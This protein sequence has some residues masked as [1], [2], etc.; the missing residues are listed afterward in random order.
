MLTVSILSAVNA[1]DHRPTGRDM[2]PFSWWLREQLDLRDWTQAD[3]S[4][5]SGVSTGLVSAWYN[6]RKTPGRESVQAIADALD[7]PATLVMTRLGL[8]AVDRVPD[9]LERVDALLK[10]VAL[11]PDRIVA[12]E[13]VL[14]SWADFDRRQRERG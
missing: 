12:L 3:F 2:Q 14:Q 7:V 5:R 10:T 9:G 1:T 8:R 4:R 11:T 6:G 13:G